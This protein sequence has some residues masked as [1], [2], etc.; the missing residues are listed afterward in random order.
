MVAHSPDMSIFSEFASGVV[1]VAHADE[2]G[3]GFVVSS[4]GLIL[5]CAHLLRGC[6]LGD[7]VRIVPHATRQPLNATIQLLRDPPDVA[8]LQLT[9]PF[10]RE[11]AVLPLG[12]SPGAPQSALRTFGYPLLRPEAGLPGELALQGFTDAADYPQLALRS[13]QVT[14]GFSGAPIWDPNTRAVVGMIISIAVA[15]PGSRLNTE[16]IGVPVEVIQ[17]VCPELQPAGFP[18]RGLK[19]L[20]VCFVSSEYPPR[21]VGGLGS[22]VEQLTAALGAL[23]GQ[24]VGVHI[25]LPSV[26]PE[27]DDYHE[28]P[29]PRVRLSPLATGNPSYSSPVSWLKFATAAA[30]RIDNMISTGASFDVIHC[31]DWVTVLV[32]IICRQR[33]GVP[34]VFHVHLPN[35]DRLCAAVENLGLASADLITVSSEAMR[36]E[37]R[38]RFQALG[39]D[40]RPVHVLNNGVDLNIFRPRDDWPNDDGYVLFVGRL[41]DQKGLEF[42]LRAF[43]Y[44]LQKFPALRLKIAGPGNP[45]PFQSLCRNLIIPNDQV[46]FVSPSLWLTREQ[47]AVLYQGARVVVLPSIYE[48]FGMTALE[49]LACQRP[50]VASRVGGLKEIITHKVNGFLAQPGDDLDVAQWLLA[51]LADAD[52]RNQ[53]GLRARERASTSDYTWP[54]IARSLV[55][56]YRNLTTPLNFD[57]PP[58]ADEIMSQIRASASERDFNPADVPDPWGTRR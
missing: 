22:H 11:V 45:A 12:R 19:P 16:V 32:G 8:L 51:L 40:F 54:A 55:H 25:I 2:A 42:L 46:E 3:A 23:V 44:A 57:K 43:Y 15:D 47:L 29:S 1:L 53:V 50:V 31:H 6:A 5:T 9:T 18:Y 30:D 39:L 24:H 36:A 34:L 17:S 48:P 21:M 20:E 41:V 13:E 14:L 28:S 27:A 4:S 7:S 10:P 33:H 58:K 26:G 56:L 52:L 35:R 37:L 38:D 49:A